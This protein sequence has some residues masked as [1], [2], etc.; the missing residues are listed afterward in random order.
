MTKTIHLF[1]LVSGEDIISLVDGVEEVSA[2]SYSFVLIQPKSVIDPTMIGNDWWLGSLL[3]RLLL[4]KT[5]VLMMLYP[6]DINEALL[7]D[8]KSYISES[9]LM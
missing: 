4:P 7:A 9:K 6:Q 2:G 1:K 8:Y 3:D 5:H